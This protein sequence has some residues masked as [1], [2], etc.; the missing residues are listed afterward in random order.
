MPSAQ[1]SYWIGTIASSL[2]WSVPTELPDGVNWLR[3]QQEQGAGGFL[4]W[5][6]FA[7]FERSVRLSAVLSVF[8]GHWELSRSKSAESYVWKVIISNL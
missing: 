5:Q 1:G 3:G 7:A 6:V 8:P 4:H 2:E